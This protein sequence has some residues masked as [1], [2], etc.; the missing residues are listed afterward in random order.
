MFDGDPRPSAELVVKAA[1]GDPAMAERLLAAERL[2]NA[3]APRQEVVDQLTEI[4]KGK[5]GA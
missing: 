3:S 1:E 2:A 4:T 5:A